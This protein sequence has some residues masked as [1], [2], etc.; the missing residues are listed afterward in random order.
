MTEKCYRPN[1]ELQ[2][3]SRPM[4]DRGTGTGMTGH[5]NQ[6]D[7]HSIAGDATNRVGSVKAGSDPADRSMPIPPAR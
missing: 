6:L 1:G 2:G 7:G 3:D 5:P 4:P